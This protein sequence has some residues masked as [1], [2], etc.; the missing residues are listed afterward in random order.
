MDGA[1]LGDL[2][3]L[4]AVGLAAGAMNAAV[5]CGTLITYPVLLGLGLS[6]ITANAT[7]TFGIVPGSAMG[8]LM[9]RRNLTGAGKTLLTVAAWTAAGAVLGAVLVLVFPASVFTAV[10]PWLIIS[11]CVLL[12]LQP[13]LARQ[14]RQP[15]VGG[16]DGA[17]APASPRWMPPAIGGVSIYGGYFGAGQQIAYLAILG[18]AHGNPH[19]A[20][21]RKNVYGAVANASAA[22]VFAIAGR[23][24]LLPA[25][26]LAVATL[27]G[28]TAGGGFA[29]RL[30]AW[31][32][33]TVIILVG[34]GTAGYLLVR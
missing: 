15:A 10:V 27:A 28:G 12:V 24:E 25:V 32:L 18:L 29:R 31:A 16:Q 20:N 13:L 9:Y 11:V 23:I 6:P 19:D 30:P 22:V 4:G 17:S 21:A 7:N 26:V 8:A 2:A 14:L 5:G 1:S 34:V 33:R 3:L